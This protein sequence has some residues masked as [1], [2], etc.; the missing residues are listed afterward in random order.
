MM[1]SFDD[2]IVTLDAPEQLATLG[3]VL[4][5][6]TRLAV[7]GVLVRADHPLHI[8]EIARRVGVDASPVRSHLELL[9]K[10][11]VVREVETESSR[12]RRFE[13]SLKNIK[14]TLEGV[15]RPKAPS[16]QGPAPK[17]VL[18]LQKKLALIERDIGRLNEKARKVQAEISAAWEKA[19]SQ[20][21]AP[22]RA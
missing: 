16:S 12:E 14:L 3:N 10:E 5:V 18:R 11:R 7:L 22:G 15:N 6:R 4:G 8:N 9:L 19:A 2:R 1:P 17:T 20:S 13:T 21:T